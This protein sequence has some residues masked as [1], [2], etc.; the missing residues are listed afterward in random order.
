MAKSSLTI[1]ISG[2]YNGRAM[3]KA[4][5]DAEKLRATYVSTMGES[6]SSM[7]NFGAKAA[8]VGGTLHNVGYKMESVGS[9]AT[10]YISVPIAAAAAACGQAAIDIDTSLT[11]VKKTVDGTEEQYQQLKDAAIEFS[12]TNAV[13]ASQILDIQALGAQLG[14]TIDELDEFSQVV[15]GLDIATDMD[16]E[17][18]ATEL[19]QFANITKMSHDVVSNYGSAIVNLGNN[20][21]TTESAISSMAM[22]TAAASTQVGMSQKEILGWSAAM[23]SLGVEAEAG[24]TAFS[25]TI[26]TIDAAVA[27]GSDDLQAFADIAGMSAEEFSASWKRSASDTLVQLLKGT[28]GAENMTVALESMGVT[29][30]RQSDVLKRLAGNTELVTEALGYARD[31]WDENI[32]LQKEVDNRNESMAAKLEILKNKV[33][34]IAE[35]VGTPLV[36]ALLDVVDA[37]DP[38]LES[39]GDIAQGFADMDEDGQKT[40]LTLVAV[41]V[42]F[43]PV[44]T[45]AGKLVQGLGNVVVG[46]GKFSQKAGLLKNE[47]T[48][49]RT[50]TTAAEGP[51]M[52]LGTAVSTLGS[53]KLP[54]VTS[55]LGAAKVALAG[56]GIGAAV[57][58]V[59]A[60][61]SAFV[62]LVEH[63]QTVVDATYG[64]ETAMGSAADAYGSYSASAEGAVK[65][66]GDVKNAT[67]DA[68]TS[69]ANLAQSM[70]EQWADYG[71]NAALV[72][73]Y[74]TEI[75][76]LTTKYDES[77]K[78]VKLTAEEQQKLKLA[79]D[80]FN[81]S[82]G[83][84]IS[85]IDAQNGTLS[86][87]IDVI[88][89]SAEAFKERARAEAAEEMYKDLYK[90]QLQNELALADATATLNDL[91][92]QE[93]DAWKY[94]VDGINPYSYQVQEAAKQVDELTAAIDSDKETQEQLI[95]V[96]LGAG[97]T[98]DSFDDALESSGVALSDFGNISDSQLQALKN[99]FDGSLTSIVTSCQQHG[100]QVPTALAAAINSN[101]EVAK[102][103]ASGLGADVDAGIKKGIE[104][105][106]DEPKSG[107]EAVGAA[108]IDFFR[109]LFGMHSPSTVMAELGAQIDAGL[110]QGIEGG[111]ESV[112]GAMGTLGTLA[113]SAIQNLPAWMGNLGSNA[114]SM[115]TDGLNNLRPSAQTAGSNLKDSVQGGISSVTN[116]LGNIGTNAANM[117][118]NAVSSVSAWASGQHVAGTARSGMSSVS[119]YNSGSNFA[120]GFANGMTGVDIWSAAYNVGLNALGAIKRALG[121]ASPSKEAKKVGA[122]FGEGAVLG[123]QSTEKAIEAEAVNLSNAMTLNPTVG[124]FDVVPGTATAYTARANGTSTSNS[125]NVTI[126]VTTNNVTEAQ[127]IGTSLADSLYT[128]YIRRERAVA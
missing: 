104:D 46:V 73:A 124:T 105:N 8:E 97:A 91:K 45:A 110:K 17:T 19:A 90:Q 16:A 6:G 74:A 95:G 53:E 92:Q 89:A 55:A 103:S 22:R 65:S 69:Q 59:G 88:K 116:T 126:N 114:G 83:S 33:T 121:I 70:S 118:S 115:L 13:S 50:A 81:E 112:T 62:E 107:I 82:T 27:T 18:A 96:M 75:E 72:D 48:L 21:A 113:Q 52:S 20:M 11:S 38:L 12:K 94:C 54:M 60:L 117:F 78:K 58:A 102:E 84:T 25:N 31:G 15:S 2:T 36:N 87:S 99:D 39:I 119:A 43:G 67:E 9:A 5:Q 66:L 44:T 34:A 26:S 42:G 77:G 7:V 1:A 10:R 57:V 85:I 108:I 14:F 123:M 51:T 101:A 40:I 120:V 68:L 98:F 29:G 128:E 125:F 100:I 64:L 30:I 127:E 111:T 28:D 23:S 79:V 49:L 35:K 24:G 4:R 122:W 32:A 47:L 37:A 76:S 80:G 86:E 109:S 71:T 56:L 41:A 106:A 93:A 3:E 63:E 61:V